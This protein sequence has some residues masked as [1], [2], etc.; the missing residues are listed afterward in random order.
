M[1]PTR[2]GTTLSI[3]ASCIRQVRICPG[4]APTLDKIP[5]WCIRAFMDIAKELRMIS[6][7]ERETIN[8]M[9]R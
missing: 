9:T 8:R 3:T 2:I 7:S 4:E 5:S 6:I 1:L